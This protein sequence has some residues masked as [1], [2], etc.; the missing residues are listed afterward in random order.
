[1]AVTV[2]LVPEYGF[3][4]DVHLVLA[5][6]NEP[7]SVEP[8]LPVTF[9]D[10][11]VPSVTVT[12][13]G[14]AKSAFLVPSAGVTETVGLLAAAFADAAGVAVPSKTPAEPLHPLSTAAAGTTPSAPSTPRRDH[15][16]DRC[17]DRFDMCE[18]PTAGLS[19]IY[20]LVRMH[21]APRVCADPLKGRAAS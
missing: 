8:S 16:P 13:T 3:L 11:S 15:F 2:Y 10:A 12:S 5:A 9:T 21:A 14:F 1:V 7:A 4:A 17:W 20:H 18:T 6:L 19:W